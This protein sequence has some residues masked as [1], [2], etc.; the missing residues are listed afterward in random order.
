[1]TPTAS[2]AVGRASAGTADR[3]D[4]AIALWE[5]HFRD[6][7]AA[8]ADA[9]ALLADRET[10]DAHTRAWCELT[11]AYH[12]LFFTASPP[13]A[14]HWIAQASER[15]AELAERRGS[16]LTEIGLARL[17][18]IESSPVPAR[19]R[20]LALY[21]EAQQVLPPQDRFWLL[22]AI[23]AAHFF[24]DRLDDAIRYLYEAL[25]A[26]R[27]SE[28][29]PQHPTV[30]SNLAAA[31]VTVGDHRPACELAEAALADLSRYDNP[32]VVLFAR[33]NYAEALTGCGEHQRA[34]DVVDAMLADAAL[35]PRRSAQNHYMAIA[36][37][38]LARRGRLDE[39]A[40]CAETA[41]AIYA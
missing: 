41:R 35:A 37:E 19:E 8:F 7:D 1:M 28:V 30:M 32:Q 17:A 9:S 18:I 25:E 3:P 16:L 6:P 21:P 38:I 40:R 22:N 36:A 26:L 31:L 29:S 34:L 11:I 5:R 14:R 39:A 10:P 4:L 20:L 23:G 2:A 13:E 24:T 27:G 12:H 33:S 15:F